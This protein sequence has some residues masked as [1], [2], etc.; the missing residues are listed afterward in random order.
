MTDKRT[1]ISQTE[2]EVLEALW[3]QGAATVR[4]LHEALLAKRR[5]AY[6]TVQTLLQRLETKGYV[7]ADR[8]AFA[9]IFRP[10]VSRESLLRQRLDALAHELCQGAKTP[11]MLALVDGQGLD[12]EDIEHLR[13][14]L[15]RLDEA[16]SA[17]RLNEST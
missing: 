4:Q 6:T 5:W 12:P 17:E 3:D 9:H 8:G 13:A 14:L 11:L 15:A 10:T 1:A 2:R 7:E 16:A